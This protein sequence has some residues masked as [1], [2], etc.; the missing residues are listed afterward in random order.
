MDITL[1]KIDT[2]RERAGISYKEAKEI[3]EKNDGDLLESLIYLE[4]NEKSWTDNISGKGDEILL[5]LKE[6]IRKGN[7]T[8][9]LLKKDGEIVMNIPVTAGAIGAVLSPPITAIAFTAALVSK[10]TLEIVKEDGEVVNISEMAEK[11]V[12]KVKRT[13]KSE[14]FYEEYKE[15]NDK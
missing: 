3:L 2:L 9:V 10:H 5:K 4:E 13:N 11:T 8:K 6:Y 12:D 15:N 7:V 14:D 1:E